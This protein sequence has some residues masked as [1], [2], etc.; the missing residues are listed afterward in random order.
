MVFF[1][2]DINSTFQ[3]PRDLIMRIFIFL[4]YIIYILNKIKKLKVER[5]I[6]KIK[7]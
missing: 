2:L 4:I 5:D 7:I 3:T 1:I 6:K